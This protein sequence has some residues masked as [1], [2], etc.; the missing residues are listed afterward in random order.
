ML[1]AAGVVLVIVLSSPLVWYV[2]GEI[3]ESRRN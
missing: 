1:M 3:I 2:I